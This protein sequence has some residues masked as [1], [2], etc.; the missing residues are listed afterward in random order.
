MP[1]SPHGA[2]R[3]A[4]LQALTIAPTPNAM[5]SLDTALAF[6]SLSVLLSL[7]PGPD[8]LFVLMQSA[9]YGRQ[10]GWWVVRGLCTGL[11]CHTVA[12]ALGLAAVFAA[13]PM[14]FVGLK[15]LGA[16]YLVYLAWGAWFASA[17]AIPVGDAQAVPTAPRPMAMWRR[18]L[19]MNV[20]NP[21]VAI[22]FLALLPQFVQPN[23]GPV[24]LQILTLGL[25]FGV[26]TALVFGGVVLMATSVR[27]RLTQSPNSQRWLNRASALVFVGLAIRLLMSPLK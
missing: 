25:L 17:N 24:A 26:A 6:F 5:P 14:A 18:G 21:K 15:V 11:V 3:P 10:A 27:E 22:F 4:S 16:G 2:A 23:R 12:V 7:V 9:T 19:I 13:S 20:T 1:E 8:N